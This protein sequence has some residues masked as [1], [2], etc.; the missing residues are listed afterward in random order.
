M[1]DYLRKAFPAQL[2]SDPESALKVVLSPEPRSVA[3]IIERTKTI[4]RVSQKDGL[5]E[6]MPLENIPHVFVAVFNKR[7]YMNLVL[8]RA[9]RF[10][11]GN[12]GHL[13][14][15]EERLRGS[16]SRSI[17]GHD[18]TGK[19]LLRYRQ[20]DLKARSA[21]GNGSLTEG[22][23]HRLAAEREFWDTFLT[24]ALAKDPDLT[25]IAVT[26]LE[27]SDENLS[28]E[29][30]HAVYFS[31][32]RFR[33]LIHRFW[34]EEVSISDQT[35]I[36]KKLSASYDADN[37]TI[38]ENEFQ[39]YLLQKSSSYYELGAF[40]DDYQKRLMQFLERNGFHFGNLK[41]HK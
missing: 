31:S 36:K 37:Q 16:R 40:V 8:D 35:A 20:A 6:V 39:A 14:T 19:D 23:R 27:S 9:S 34:S 2:I 21:R 29:V 25:L 1:K 12:D 17:A 7:S 18:L 15:D 32:A 30:L 13:L 38:V 28:H 24:P 10:I 5:V 26:S 33:K 41:F 4:G 3:G 22:E 11:E